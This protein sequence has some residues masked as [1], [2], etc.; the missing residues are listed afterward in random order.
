TQG[1][2]PLRHRDRVRRPGDRPAPLH[3]LPPP[4]LRQGGAVPPD[5]EEVAAPATGRR[6]P[7]GPPVPAG[8]V[9]GVLQ[10]PTPSPGGGPTDPRGGVRRPTQGPAPPTG[11]VRAGPLPDPTRSHRLR[12]QGD[13]S[14]QQPAAPHRGGSTTRRR[15][16]PHPR[17]RPRRADPL[18]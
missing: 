2:G 15:S 1:W 12:R 9:P 7:P 10:H 14:V 11:S 4:D 17:C 5:A 16:G 3:P 13:P 6:L 8:L 18:G